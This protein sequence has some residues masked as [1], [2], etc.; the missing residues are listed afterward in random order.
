MA[1]G[2]DPASRELGLSSAVIGWTSYPGSL[3]AASER[4]LKLRY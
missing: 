3:D 1:N 4:R 2:R